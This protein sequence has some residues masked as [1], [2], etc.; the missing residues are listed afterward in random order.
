[1][2]DAGA[3]V[4]KNDI[5]PKGDNPEA[6]MGPL[7]GRAMA[8]GPVGDSQRQIIGDAITDRVDDRAIVIRDTVAC[9]AKCLHVQYLIRARGI[10]QAEQSS[11]F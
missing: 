9:G 2:S 7:D 1:M 3:G 4:L 10:D 5:I 6:G 8:I 11:D